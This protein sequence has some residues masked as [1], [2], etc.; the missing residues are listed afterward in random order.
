MIT[1]SRDHTVTL[2][3][4]LLHQ[5]L[6]RGIPVIMTW[7]S[8]DPSAVHTLF[9]DKSVHWNF[10]LDLLAD[11]LDAPAGNGDLKVS[12]EGPRGTWITITLDSPSGHCELKARRAELTPFIAACR[13]HATAAGTPE[14][15]FDGWL[16]ELTSS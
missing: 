8:R 14:P 13:E 7:T 10:S 9:T 5:A 12:P 11:G 2:T 6:G 15:D 16:R 3:T 1:V 4:H